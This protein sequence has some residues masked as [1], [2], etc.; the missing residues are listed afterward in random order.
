[1][2]MIFRGD[3]DRGLD[4]MHSI[5]HKLVLEKQ[6]MWDMPCQITAEGDVAFG[7]EYF[8][9]TM[10]WS[11]PMAVLGQEVEVFCGCSG[12]A[13]RIVAAATADS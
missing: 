4:L 9:N 7:L 2:L 8:H 5:W 12:L 10:L 6:N 11:L 3:P 13:G 1:M